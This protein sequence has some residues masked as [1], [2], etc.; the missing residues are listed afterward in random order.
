MVVNQLFTETPSL[1]LIN[2]FVATIGLKDVTDTTT[3]TFLD[4]I[5][6]NTTIALQPIHKELIELYLPCKR[7]YVSNLTHKNIITVLRQL[8][9]VIDYDL[10][11][12]E[13]FI[14]GTKYIE[15]RIATKN[16]KQTVKT[17]KNNKK[18]KTEYII[19]FD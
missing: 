8:L 1:E 6:H 17:T 10:I 9:K 2:K 5:Q 13:K 16:E 7:T 14:Q 18:K 11:S 15:Y 3:F 12:K 4:M 19:H